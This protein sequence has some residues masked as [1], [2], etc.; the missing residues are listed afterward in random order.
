MKGVKYIS[1]MDNSGY[2]VAARAYISALCDAG[3]KITWESVTGKQSK[4]LTLSPDLQSL[5]YEAIDYD[6]VIIHAMPS[7]Y[8]SFVEAERKAGKK[9]F[10]FTV[11]EHDFLPEGWADE[12]NTLDAVMVPCVWNKECFERSGVV[13]PIFVVPH[14]SQFH[15]HEM[16]ELLKNENYKGVS[17][18]ISKYSKLLRD[19]KKNNTTIFYHI[20]FWSERKNPSAVI[21]AY[22]NEFTSDDNVLL[23]IKTSKKDLTWRGRSWRSFF[24]KKTLG[25][26]YSYKKI[27][28]SYKKPARVLFID[29][30]D[31]SSDDLLAIH[32]Y[33]DCFV[34]LARTEGWGMGAFDATLLANPVI[35]TGYGGQLDFIKHESSLI[36]DYQLV[37]VNE[38]VWNKNY[39]D[40]HYWA[41]P[42]ILHAQK[43]MR[44][45]F[46]NKKYYN[47]RAIELANINNAEFSSSSIINKFKLVFSQAGK[48]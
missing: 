8:F 30:E 33:S 29:R 14:L 12:I 6:C 37:P 39:D 31:L 26:I 7:V 35:M 18:D 11:W 15:G 16:Y 22:L 24:R 42:D 44:K 2:S 10:G 47:D 34:S 3:F 17:L 20:G 27:L 28:K 21:K 41:D 48:I 9:I 38:P 40:R 23:V 36:V 32:F 19:F 46:E 43:L 5:A 25:T 45:Y 1:Y 13:I 4:D